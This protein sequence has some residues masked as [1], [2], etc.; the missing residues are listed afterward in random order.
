MS[1]QERIAG[2]HRVCVAPLSRLTTIHSILCIS[3]HHGRGLASS[4]SVQPTLVFSQFQNSQ[5]VNHRD[6]DWSAIFGWFLWYIGDL[7]GERLR[8]HR[9]SLLSGHFLIRCPRP[10]SHWP[11]IRLA[12]TS[13]HY[14]C[15][16]RAPRWLAYSGIC[17]RTDQAHGGRETRRWVPS[18]R[19]KDCLLALFWGWK[20]WALLSWLWSVKFVTD[21]ESGSSQLSERLPHLLTFGGSKIECLHLHLPSPVYN[22]YGSGIERVPRYTGPVWSLNSSYLEI[23]I[24]CYYRWGWGPCICSFPSSAA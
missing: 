6:G 17:L 13:S 18:R 7:S 14:F 4:I 23:D 11:A 24:G 10:G 20:S 5:L 21:K 19:R 8:R 2:R 1:G 9:L 22:Q 12:S 3:G 15:S 16:C